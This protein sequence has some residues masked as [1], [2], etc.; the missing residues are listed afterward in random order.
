M[1][2]SDELNAIKEVET[3]NKKFHGLTEEELE[4]V[5]GGLSDEGRI[6]L[7]AKLEEMIRNGKLTL[8]EYYTIYEAVVTGD[9]Q[10]IDS[11]LYSKHL[12]DTEWNKLYMFYLTLR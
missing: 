9:D 6:A 7:R 1:K 8:E 5:N 11:W 4:Q 10:S 2:T 3:V 12:I